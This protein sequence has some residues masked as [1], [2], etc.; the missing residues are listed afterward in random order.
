MPRDPH[1]SPRVVPASCQPPTLQRPPTVLRAP[2]PGSHGPATTCQ[3]LT[4]PSGAALEARARARRTPLAYRNP[5]R[6]SQTQ[7]RLFPTPTSLPPTLRPLTGSATPTVTPTP[8]PMWGH[9]S[10]SKMIR[11]PSRPPARHREC[12]YSASWIGAV[13]FGCRVGAWAD[14]PPPP[15]PAPVTTLLRTTVS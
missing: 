10:D 13:R 15:C 8:T 7:S 9:M 6:T 11:A 1:P 2:P 3:S 4:L 12:G 14:Y 5:N